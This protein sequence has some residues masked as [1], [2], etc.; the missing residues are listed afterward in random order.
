[1]ALVTIF[2]EK[3]DRIY[4]NDDFFKNKS[5]VVGQFMVVDSGC[6]RSLL[7]EYELE[8]L[9]KFME[10]E[11]IDVKEESFRFGP[12]KIYTSNTKIVFPIKVGDC[13]IDF[14]FFVVK[15]MIPM[16]LGNDVMV[17]LGGKVDLAE[18]K[19]ELK[20]PGIEIPLVRTLGGHFVIPVKSIADVKE[21]NE[22]KN[23][24]IRSKRSDDGITG[25]YRN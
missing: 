18:S 13:Q 5:K 22:P 4:I 19:L 6:P 21:N 3:Y 20:K 7:G 2:H 1:M 24:E 23:A 11:V 12:S 8:I 14:E 10:I 15:A 25:K 9:R 17:P 16:L